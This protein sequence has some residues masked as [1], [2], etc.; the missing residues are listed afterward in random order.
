MSPI[1][2]VQKNTDYPLESAP[3][4]TENLEVRT[5]SSCFWRVDRMLGVVPNA[6]NFETEILGRV[7]ER[8]AR[9]CVCAQLC[10][11]QFCRLSNRPRQLKSSDKLHIQAERERRQVEVWRCSK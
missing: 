5:E 8:T 7:E 1:G 2:V 6:Q 4:E 11:V 10:I 3:K 9:N